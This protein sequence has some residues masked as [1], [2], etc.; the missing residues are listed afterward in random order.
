MKTKTKR[1]ND[2][3]IFAIDGPI[4]SG[5]EF[6]LA[7]EL[8]TF[9]HQSDV[10]KIIVDMKKV[11]FINSAALGIFLS[12]F[13]EVEKKNGRFGICSLS[14]DVENLLEIT[15]LDSVLEVFKNQEDAVESF[16]D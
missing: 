14:A 4:K 12:I 5:M 6:T 10:P 3:W 8:E 13:R 1:K 15:K 11:P 7:D 9:L 16:Q 2:L